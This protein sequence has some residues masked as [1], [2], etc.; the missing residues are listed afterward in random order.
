M[1]CNEW[2]LARTGAQLILDAPRRYRR[3]AAS[4]PID[5][6]EAA[7]RARTLLSFSN[8]VFLCEPDEGWE[9]EK[10]TNAAVV[11]T[12]VA[13][14]YA[15][16][17]AEW[18]SGIPEGAL[19][20][21]ALLAY[22]IKSHGLDTWSIVKTSASDTSTSLSS[23]MSSGEYD[24]G[25]Y[26][27]I[28]N[29]SWKEYDSASFA[30]AQQLTGVIEQYRQIVHFAEGSDD[31]VEGF[32]ALR[33]IIV[34]ELASARSSVV[35]LQVYGA[36]AEA[37][38]ASGLVAALLRNAYLATT[39]STVDQFLKLPIMSEE[40]LDAFLEKHRLTEWLERVLA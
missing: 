37:I 39:V 36:E 10:M 5:R 20:D 18:P 13:D 4:L 14:G 8:E 23:D 26:R 29:P 3:F 33:L 25:R 11:L 31:M 40:F 27:A 19:P 22:E 28:Q 32:S 16:L 6:E 35:R 21:Q 30:A 15:M 34:Q 2:D 24:L 9:S 12:G 38:V 17:S 7:A 1:N